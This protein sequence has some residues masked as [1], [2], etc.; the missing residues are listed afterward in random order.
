MVRLEFGIQA[1]S[2]RQGIAVSEIVQTGVDRGLAIKGIFL[3]AQGAPKTE[4]TPQRVL[5]AGVLDSGKPDIR[6][7]L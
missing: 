2:S 5:F 4:A 7:R 6:V 3:I 1:Y